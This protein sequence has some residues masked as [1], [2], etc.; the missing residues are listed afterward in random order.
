MSDSFLVI[1]G[2]RQGGVLSA[3][4]WAVYMDDLIIKLRKSGMGCHIIDYF[5]ACILYAD[6]VC[7]LTPSRKSMQC[8]LDI[9]S[10]YASLWCIK[11]KKRSRKIRI[12]GRSLTHFL[13]VLSHIITLH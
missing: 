4:F 3:R 12:L 1:S 2:V 8:L 5:V 10:E 11:N 7:L 9:C 13:A 6:D